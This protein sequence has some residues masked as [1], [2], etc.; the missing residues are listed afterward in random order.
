M[1]QDNFAHICW[2]IKAKES[3]NNWDD[4]LTRMKSAENPEESFKIL[5][6]TYFSDWFEKNLTA[7]DFEKVLK[8]SLLNTKDF[9]IKRSPEKWIINLLWAW[10][11]YFNLK[12][13]L[14]A[15][16]K[17]LE[18]Q[19]IEQHFSVFWNIQLKEI[20]DVVYDWHFFKIERLNTLIRKINKEYEKTKD[21]RVVDFLAD[22]DLYNFLLNKSKEIWAT[23]IY[24]FHIRKIDIINTLT[25]LRTYKDLFNI[26]IFIKWWTLDMK[27]LENWDKNEINNMIKVKICNFWKDYDFFEEKYFLEIESELEKR[28]NYYIWKINLQVY[29]KEVVFAHFYK[30]FQMAKKIRRILVWKLNNIKNV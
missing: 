9:L 2:A 30:K 17:W 22:N 19:N 1:P 3:Q 27:I 14:K 25:Y 10:F 24:R 21:I 11:D 28:L 20:K 15:K 6:D 13:F 8:K 26:N 23:L 29:W 5:N 18:F 7:I 4:I 16:L 12:I